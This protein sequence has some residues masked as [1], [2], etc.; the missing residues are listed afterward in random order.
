MRRSRGGEVVFEERDVCGFETVEDGE[1]E[2]RETV[3]AGYVQNF[4]GEGFGGERF[5]LGDVVPSP[6]SYFGLPGVRNR[7]GMVGPDSH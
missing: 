3:S 5:G 2:V 7:A 4:D 6:L 1:C